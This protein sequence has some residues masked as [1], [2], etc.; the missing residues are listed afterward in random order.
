MIPKNITQTQNDEIESLKAK[1]SKIE[2]YLHELSLTV[3]S[4]IEN[5][6]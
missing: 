6:P 2:Q 4:L 1:V 5:K 3:Q